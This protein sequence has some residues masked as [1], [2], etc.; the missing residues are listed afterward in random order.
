VTI[1]GI[2]DRRE[3]GGGRRLRSRDAMPFDGVCRVRSGRK[4]ICLQLEA[5]ER[6]A[7]GGELI[8]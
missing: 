1:V 2:H 4:G 3:G 6:S 5:C 7:F 8:G